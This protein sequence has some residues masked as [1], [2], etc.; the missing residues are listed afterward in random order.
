MVNNYIKQ[1]SGGDFTAKDF[2]TWAGTVQALI[3]FKELG[4]FEDLEEPSA[5]ERALRQ[6]EIH[7]PPIFLSSALHRRNSPTESS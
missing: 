6:A 7:R 3:T 5:I 2:R 4:F 1:L